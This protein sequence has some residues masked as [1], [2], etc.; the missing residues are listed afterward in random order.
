[1]P[2][3]IGEVA[4]DIGLPGSTGGAAAASDQVREEAL[5]RALERLR[6]I[7]ARTAGDA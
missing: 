3:E 5:R 4:V 2:V 1:V 7:D 6:E